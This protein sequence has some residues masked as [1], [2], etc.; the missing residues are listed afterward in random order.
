MYAQVC[1]PFFISKTF[2]YRVPNQLVSNLKSGDLVEVKFKNKL[3]KGFV[4]STSSTISFKGS[5]NNIISIDLTNAIPYDLWK[6][7]L[8][9]SNYYVTPIGKITQTTLS[10][11]FKNNT[12]KNDKIANNNYTTKTLDSLNLTTSQNQIYNKVNQLYKEDTKPQFLYGVPGSGKTE[13]YLKLA[14]NTISN[15]QSCLVLIPEIAL[16]SQIFSR[17]QTY[18]GDKVLLWHSQSTN[19][20]KRKV[21]NKLQK[22]DSYIIVGARSALFTPIHNLGLIIVDEE[23]DSSYKETERQP[24]YHARDL[25][26]I[27]AQYSKALILLGSATP[28][29]ETY[30]NAII[31]NK[32]HIHELNERYGNAQLPKVKIVDMNQSRDIQNNQNLFSEYLI[33]KIDASLQKKEQIL[34]LHN[35]R[36][37]SSIKVCTESDDILKCKNCDVIL[38]FHAQLNQLICHHCNKKY[39]FNEYTKKDIQFL[40]YGTEQIEAILNQILPHAR[41]LRMDSDSANSMKK[42]NDILTRFKNKEYDILLGTQMIAKGLDFSNITLVAVMNAEL[43]ML[44]P[45]YRSHEK[46]F[47][48]IYQVIGRSGRREKIGQAIIQTYNPDNHLIQ[49]ATNYQSKKFYNLNLESRKSLQ[50]PPFVRLIRFLF[51]ST[52]IKQC[53]ASAHKIYKL[54][55]IDFAHFII[56]PLPCPIERLSNKS[57]Y[58]ILLKIKPE[59]LKSSLVKIKNIQDRKSQL[60]NNKVSLLIDIDSISV[61]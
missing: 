24:C 49:M 36:G 51:Q 52:D 56:G 1:F 9:M 40:G 31:I 5:V 47:Q 2:T 22:R 46:M 11:A 16:S 58:H 17:F 10:W 61:L 55:K 45:D 27:R 28:S 37:F 30:Y 7:L 8:W 14:Q 43:G 50:Y 29:L 25:A 12:V 38:T 4:V 26:I 41:I 19:L 35:R 33:N 18:F 34:I 39:S 59:K 42:Q 6:T 32:Y 54:L 60:I 48:L 20:Y 23:H 13:I 53:I 3:C 15:N 44:I 21:L 57:R